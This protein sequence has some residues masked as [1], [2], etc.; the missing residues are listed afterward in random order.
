MSDKR[1]LLTLG[2]GAIHLCLI[3]VVCCEET[4]ALV[5]AQLTILPTAC[6]SPAR[7]LQPSFA[8]VLRRHCVAEDRGRQLIN[9]YLHLAGIESSY[10]FFAPNV[11]PAY[12]LVFEF[13]Y[14]DGRVDYESAGFEGG[15]TS[16]RFA[17]LLD[18]LGRLQFEAGREY[19]IHSLATSAWQAHP[20]AVHVRAILGSLVYPPP[21]Q[22]L[23][24]P[25]VT[26][27]FAAAYTFSQTGETENEGQ[28]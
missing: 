12:K 28:P 8:A 23:V 26:Y 22:F 4:L 18:Y 24:D 15:E 14:N 21:H 5:S 2:V 20:D 13:T 27:Q 6:S 7:K 3:A 17:S 1:Q 19:L 25:T 9:T 10:N 16:L 11:P